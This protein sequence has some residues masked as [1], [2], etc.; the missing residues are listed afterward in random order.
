MADQAP[1]LS[2]PIVLT[3]SDIIDLEACL[4]KWL[5]RFPETSGKAKI[6]LDPAS[7]RELRNTIHTWLCHFVA[8]KNLV[9]QTSIWH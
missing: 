9:L 5:E 4:N 7:L 1:Q 8:S 3:E 6:R 2:N